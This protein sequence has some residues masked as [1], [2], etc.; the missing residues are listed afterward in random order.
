[1]VPEVGELGDAVTAKSALMS[2]GNTGIDELDPLLAEFGSLAPEPALTLAVLVIVLP[3]AVSSTDMVILTVAEA[4]LDRLGKLQF[5]AVAPEAEQVTP[6]VDPVA[7]RKVATVAPDPA[8]SSGR[9]SNRVAALA[10]EGPELV[11]TILKVTAL[12]GTEQLPGFV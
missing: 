5:T 4:P 3:W 6:D 10:V 2:V 1:M 7:L 11:T 9:V 12:Q 8:G